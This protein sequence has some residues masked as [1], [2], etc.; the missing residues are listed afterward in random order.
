MSA[1]VPIF[2]WG[3]YTVPIRDD[4]GYMNNANKTLRFFR[5]LDPRTAARLAAIRL[6]ARGLARCG[7]R[8]TKVIPCETMAALVAGIEGAS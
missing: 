6:R 3:L 2:I 5:H 1:F 8:A 4:I 7:E